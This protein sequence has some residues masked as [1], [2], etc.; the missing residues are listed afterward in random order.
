MKGVERWK[1]FQCIQHYFN[2]FI[3]TLFQQYYFNKYEFQRISTYLFQLISTIFQHLFQRIYRMKTVERRNLF[4]HYFNIFNPPG[5]LMRAPGAGG[6]RWG[7]CGRRADAAVAATVT[8][9]AR[10]G[11]RCGGAARPRSRPRASQDVAGGG[12]GDD[13]RRPGGGGAGEP[14][15]GGAGGSARACMR[16]CGKSGQ[17][18]LGLRAPA[19]A[20]SRRMV[21]R[22]RRPRLVEGGAGSPE[23]APARRP[24]RRRRG[25]RGAAT[26]ALARRARSIPDPRRQRPGGRAI[27]QAKIGED[28]N[29]R[30]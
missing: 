16:A 21:Q 9:R 2:R 17:R 10:C 1:L 29:R 28:T 6:A 30:R 25:R 7:G 26:R 13:T 22:S 11:G 20:A 27:G 14:I 24:P 23:A 18:G 15:M 5:S 4:Q 3:S 8:A 19:E 12:G